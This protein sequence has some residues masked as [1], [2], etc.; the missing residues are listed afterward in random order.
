MVTYIIV[1]LLVAS[2]AS[3]LLG[4]AYKWGLIEYVQ[5]H[6]HFD[7]IN[8]MFSCQFCLSFWT[9]MLLSIV[10]VALLN[11]WI[12]FLVP[13]FSTNITKQLI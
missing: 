9:G 12:F 2:A 8:R 11:D 5:V 3:W 7:I 4:L 10:A 1:V 6:T 13:I